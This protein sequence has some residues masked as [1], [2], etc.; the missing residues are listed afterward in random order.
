MLWDMCWVSHFSQ[1][2]SCCHQCTQVRLHIKLLYHSWNIV[3]LVMLDNSL[4]WVLVL[5]LLHP[6]H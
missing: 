4:L 3:V 6:Q 5:L 2:L 1:A